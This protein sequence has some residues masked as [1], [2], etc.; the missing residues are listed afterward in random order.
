V[1]TG[2]AGNNRLTGGNGADVLEGG[3][4]D[5]ILDGGAHTD[6]ATYENAT[7]GVTVSLAI[8][9][10]Q[11]TIGAGNDQLISIERLIGSDFDD[12]LT[13]GNG[14]DKLEGGLG[15]DI[16]SGGNGY[17]FV[18]Y[19][20]ATAGVTVDLSAVG[21]QNTGGAGVDTLISIE[22]ITGS[23]YD[24]VLTGTSGDNV[25]NGGDGIDMVRYSN[26]TAGVTVDLRITDAQNAGGSGADTLIGI[27]NLTGSAYKDNL[28][29]DAGN[30]I[31]NGGAGADR[32]VGGLG[33]DIYYVD[34]VGDVVVETAGGGND[35]L[36]AAIDYTLLDDTIETLALI[37][38]AALTAK[39]TAQANHLI[40]NDGDNRLTGLA[41]DDILSG[42]GGDDILHGGVG[43]DV[44]DGGAGSDSATYVDATSGVTV[45]LTV[46]VA[47]N[48][49]GG[50]IDTLTSIEKVTGS[51][52]DDSLTGNADNNVLDGG[53]GADLMIGGLGDDTY[54]VDN[55]GDIVVEG[56]NGGKDTI[57][58][59]ISYVL[60]SRI[61]ETLNLTGTAAIDG[62]GNNRANRITGN[63]GN[64]VLTGMG[65]NDTL[66][67]GNGSDLLNG[68]AGNDVMDGG[69]HIDTVTYED[70][71]GGITVSLAISSAQDTGGS[72]VDTLI[73]IERL[74]GSGFDDYL[75]GNAGDDRLTAGA[76]DDM[77]EGGLGYNIVDG[78]IGNDTVNYA[79]ASAG[80]TVKLW[81]SSSEQNTFGA[82]KDVLIGIE[83]AIGSAFN[84]EL[85]GN[86]YDNHLIGGTGDDLLIG[87]DGNDI[88]DGGAGTDTV[89]YIDSYA[90]VTVNLALTGPQDSIGRGIS[91]LIS[92]ENLTGSKFDDVLTGDAG[93]NRIAG[94][95]GNDLIMGGPGDDFIDG[96]DGYD[97][98]SYADATSGV[99]VS[100]ATVTGGGVGNDTLRFVEHL[101]G[102]AYDD[103][104]TG[105]IDFNGGA[106]DDRIY[107]IR[108]YGGSLYGDAGDDMLFGGSGSDRLRGGEGNDVL[109]GGG[110]ADRFYLMGDS[111]GDW[112]TDFAVGQDEIV[113]TGAD[114]GLAAGAL[115]QN[116][117]AVDAPSSTPNTFIYY[118]DDGSLWWNGAQLATLSSNLDLTASD[119]LVI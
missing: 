2:D 12:K 97:T 96:G 27:E 40:G 79:R 32:M 68:G 64:N 81:R 24:D 19:V 42:G 108:N 5:D 63:S 55:V 102:S 10:V 117:F 22:N 66:I 16:L 28:T 44:M 110:G 106:G 38:T 104:L 76:G 75:I 59:S 98:V 23:S 54:Y 70:A 33:D 60:G 30:N 69:N 92:I 53:T 107:N 52:Y 82:G 116:A 65:G 95:Q 78:G 80:V 101:I 89:S 56:E 74:I 3:A 8:A 31:L 50:G 29:G 6:T 67:G 58:S 88:L 86:G 62:T 83:N 90:G 115:P 43:N 36:Y 72:G 47:Q 4:G 21:A 26:A 99:T 73:G 49:G 51:Q 45:D 18:R 39:G 109:T 91:T 11:S 61:V 112:I 48:T 37:G 14:D 111:S 93:N 85:S 94:E 15:N 113:L 100:S 87:Y 35:T 119:F 25:L 41:G 34:N 77:L 13:G 20:T 57:N 7:A 105:S 17:D 118:E 71:T 103:V 114:F 84:D 46:S 1:L 9:G